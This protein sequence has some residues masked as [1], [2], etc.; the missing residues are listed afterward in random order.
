MRYLDLSFPEPHLNLACDEFLLNA[1]ESGAGAETL[2]FWESPSPFVVLGVSQRL[3]E[4]V[5]EEACARDGIPILR[6]AS[7][8]G[9]VLQGPG[10]LNYALIL[11]RTSRPRLA[12]IRSSYCEI[13]DRLS[14]AFA[15]IGLHVRHAGISD[16]V[17]EGKKVSG[18]AQR[19]RKRFILHHG[20][21][22]YN[23][24]T[25]MIKEYLREPRTQPEYRER[26]PHDEFVLN[27]ECGAD[28]LRKLVRD[29][30]SVSGETV[31]VLDPAALAEIESLATDKYSDAAWIRKR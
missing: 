25:A 6:R 27:L 10:C 30:F 5:R 1:A 9:C 31:R 7:A 15:A 29:A 17:L 18:N 28:Q 4:E 8:G 16:L 22:L 20:T 19:R 12:S 11:D 24:D 23:F 3:H 2:R 14:A 21:F 13:F 26:R